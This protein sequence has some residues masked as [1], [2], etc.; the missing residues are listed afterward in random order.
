MK[1]VDKMN[2]AELLV[3]LAKPYLFQSKEEH[4][5]AFKRY[6]NLKVK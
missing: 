4:M 2:K 6:K 1:N 5:S 3:A